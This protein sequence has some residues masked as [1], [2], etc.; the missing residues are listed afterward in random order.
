ML[1]IAMRD[2]LAA[3]RTKAFI[4]SLIFL[5]LMIGSSIGIQVFLQNLEKGREKKYAVIDRT[6]GQQ[7]WQDLARLSTQHNAEIYNPFAVNAAD[8]HK[9][10]PAGKD[11]DEIEKQCLALSEQVRKSKID[12]FFVIGPKVFEPSPRSAEERARARAGRDK[13]RPL[14][15]DPYAVQYQAKNPAADEF[16]GRVED[17]LNRV[18]HAKRC[19]D[20]N[21]PLEKVGRIVAPVPLE[22]IGLAEERDG[23]IVVPS[24]VGMVAPLLIPAGLMTVMFM[25]IMVGAT[26]LMQG[27]VEEKMQRI[28]EV[29]LGSVRPFT[30]MMGKLLGTVA[31][32]MTIAAVYLG[33]AYY[34]AYWHWRDEGVSRYLPVNL[35]GW[36]LLFQMLAILMYGSVFIAI[37]AA[38]T[39]MRETQTLMW[40]VTLLACIPMFMVSSVITDPNSSFVTGASFFPPATPMLMVARQA[41]PPGID[42]WQPVVGALGVLALTF[43]CVYAAGRIFR[44]G[45]LMQGK[46]AKVSELLKWVFQ[47]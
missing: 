43:V 47:G 8:E 4:I 35:I 3:V 33:A 27:V 44:V 26:P 39:D 36:F 1:I 28:A 34:A 46:G 5:P 16:A 30:L 20:V 25:L 7:L 37:G 12:G 45:L 2:Y 38:C 23:R 29:L 19:Q 31:V 9:P 22:R 24:A 40:P 18:I 13:D 10:V 32:S 6:P 11:R 15:D 42:W 14:P 41:V 17:E 21:V